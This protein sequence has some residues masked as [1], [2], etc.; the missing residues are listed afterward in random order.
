MCTIRIYLPEGVDWMQEA[1]ASSE[2]IALTVH[3]NPEFTLQQFPHLLVKNTNKVRGEKQAL[4]Q[5]CT[6]L[7]GPFVPK[8]HDS[9]SRIMS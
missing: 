4:A 3:D 8:N 7:H 1:F 5:N 2:K 9:T 6:N